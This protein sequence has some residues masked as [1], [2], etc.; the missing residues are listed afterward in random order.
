MAY[1]QFINKRT[2]FPRPILLRCEYN[3]MDEDMMNYCIA[4]KTDADPIRVHNG[5]SVKGLDLQFVIKLNC[6]VSIEYMCFS[7]N[8]ETNDLRLSAASYCLLCVMKVDKAVR[9]ICPLISLCYVPLQ[10]ITNSVHCLHPLRIVFSS[11]DRLQWLCIR[12]YCIFISIFHVRNYIH[13]GSFGN[14]L[15][16]SLPA[17]TLSSISKRQH[18]WWEKKHRPFDSYKVPSISILD[19]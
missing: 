12:I 2:R 11:I 15:L 8:H 3:R 19:C 16:F 18:R 1:W 14:K 10:L 7:L 5:F 13:F 4:V 9:Q 6:S 17:I